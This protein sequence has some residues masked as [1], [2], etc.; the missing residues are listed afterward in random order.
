M[1]SDKPLDKQVEEWISTQIKID[2]EK[3]DALGE[4]Y[5]YPLSAEQMKELNQKLTEAL[6]RLEK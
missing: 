4:I 3:Y 6:K 2:K 5:V 1:E